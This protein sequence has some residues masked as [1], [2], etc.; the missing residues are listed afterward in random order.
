MTQR[1]LKGLI[2]AV[3]C[4]FLIVSCASS[5]KLTNTFVDT[6]FQGQPVSDVLVIAVTDRDALRRSFEGKFVAQLKAAGIEA[7]SSAN[8]I[9]IPPSRELEKEMILKAVEDHKND[10]VMITRLIGVEEKEVYT[11]PSRPSW[12]YYGD[13]RHFHA[14]AHEPGH[15][16]TNTLI[17]LATNLYDV[18]TERLMWSG[19]SE[20]L[21]PNSNKELIDQ[22]IR[23]VVSDLQK[24][25][26][27]PGAQE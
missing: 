1:L 11:R 10:A 18:K 20:T 6:G 15:S 13:Y 4:G 17:R 24:K 14:Y 21:N 22:V 7:V 5:S 16:R 8:A 3:F 26:L 19:E 9:P 27:L 25:G 2:L 23:L 12:G